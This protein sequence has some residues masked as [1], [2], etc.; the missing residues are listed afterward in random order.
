MERV[1]A[2]VAHGLSTVWYV[3]A[4]RTVDAESAAQAVRPL[5][6]RSFDR[7]AMTGLL[8]STRTAWLDSHTFSNP[9]QRCVAPLR[10]RCACTPRTTM[11]L[12]GS[13][14][15]PRSRRL[16]PVYVVMR[17]MA[18]ALAAATVAARL[19]PPRA[20]RAS[21][22]RYSGVDTPAVRLRRRLTPGRIILSARRR[23]P[24]S[25]HWR[26]GI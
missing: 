17:G 10:V 21:S 11:A 2:V 6:S 18:A 24:W 25:P 15:A 19:A 7:S 5:R 26:G 20:L 3:S 22:D 12:G 9:P 23:G 13:H 1:P 4:N 14:V 8:V 16:G